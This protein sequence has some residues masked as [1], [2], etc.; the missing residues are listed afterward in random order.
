MGKLQLAPDGMPS[1]IAPQRPGLQDRASWGLMLCFALAVELEPTGG[2]G[3]DFARNR[4]EAGAKALA[5]CPAEA[6]GVA[7]CKPRS[8]P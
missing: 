1:R 2:Y 4:N 8:V 6:V 3:Q 7:L 5:R